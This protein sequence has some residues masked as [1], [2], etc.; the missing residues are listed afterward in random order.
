MS[1]DDGKVDECVV[2]HCSPTNDVQCDFLCV[3][4]PPTFAASMLLV[5]LADATGGWAVTHTVQCHRNTRI[6]VLWN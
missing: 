2:R 4:C 5:D 6:I 3:R 1:T